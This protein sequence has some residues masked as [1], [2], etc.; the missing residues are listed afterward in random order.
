MS[1]SD[2]KEEPKQQKSKKYLN[3]GSYKYYIRYPVPL[4]QASLF[5]TGLA[6]KQVKKFY[7]I[8]TAFKIA[9]IVA[10]VLI[11]LL[12]IGRL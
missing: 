2:A 8:S 4:P 10:V 12:L 5:Q 9:K 3:P 6:N 7:V 1:S 11:A